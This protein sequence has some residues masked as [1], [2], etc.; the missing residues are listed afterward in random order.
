MLIGGVFWVI[1]SPDM[2][3]SLGMDISQVKTLLY[4]FSSLFFG[5]LTIV[6]VFWLFLS[7][8]RVATRKSGKLKFVI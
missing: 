7:I 5:I 4:L 6:F 8:Y 1:Q 2:L 3:E